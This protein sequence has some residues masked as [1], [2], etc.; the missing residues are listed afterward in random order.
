MR[1]IRAFRQNRTTKR[2]ASVLGSNR[3][4]VYVRAA[5]PQQVAR[6]LPPGR[7]YGQLQALRFPAHDCPHPNRS[8][9]CKAHPPSIHDPAKRRRAPGT[10]PR[11]THACGGAGSL[12]LRKRRIVGQFRSE[13]VPRRYPDVSHRLL[14]LVKMMRLALAFGM[15][16]VVA[17]H[18]AMVQPRTRNSVEYQVGVNTQRCA[19]ITG[20]ACN[21]G[22]A[23]F[24]YLLRSKLAKTPGHTQQRL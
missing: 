6:L 10:I 2:E 22:Q 5:T 21:N 24:W 13:P 17:G 18:G 1:R 16:G 11:I 15:V 12:D 14:D 3:H 7:H 20:D 8:G 23:A 9:A 19:N 4:R